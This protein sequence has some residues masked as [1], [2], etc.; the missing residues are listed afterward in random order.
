MALPESHRESL[1]RY[2]RLDDER[3]E[4]LRISHEAITREISRR[5]IVVQGRPGDEERAPN[6]KAGGIPVLI[7]QR[8][9]IEQ[10]IGIREALIALGRD[11]RV[12]DILGELAGNPDLAR[13]AA[14]DPRAFA[15]DR[16]IEVPTNMA[17]ELDAEDERVTLRVTYY[18]EL[19]PF[20]LMWNSED[21]FSMPSLD[22][23]QAAEAAA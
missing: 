13:E 16:G 12:L 10:E 2:L 5:E 20:V 6:A 17:L 3:L 19:A 8:E 18:D 9:V 14:R 4:A 21:G 23:R 7:S 15:S 11:P 22:S 1:E